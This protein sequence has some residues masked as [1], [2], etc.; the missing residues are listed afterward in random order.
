MQQETKQEDTEYE[1]RALKVLC[2]EASFDAKA[3][4]QEVMKRHFEK[5]QN[6]VASEYKHDESA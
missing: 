2:K 3:M 5:I 6:I 4:H 1:I